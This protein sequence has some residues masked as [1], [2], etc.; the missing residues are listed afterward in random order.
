MEEIDAYGEDG[1]CSL[2]LFDAVDSLKYRRDC[3][4][5]MERL[6]QHPRCWGGNTISN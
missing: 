1:G 4:A 5:Y 6:Q 2:Q 3:E